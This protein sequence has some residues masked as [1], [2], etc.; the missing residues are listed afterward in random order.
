MSRA[1]RFLQ[2]HPSA[3]IFGLLVGVWLAFSWPAIEEESL[4]LF[5][6]LYPPAE[7]SAYDAIH[8]GETIQ[9]SMQVK[10]LRADCEY[11]GRAAYGRI[12][13]RGL[14]A[15]VPLAR[16]DAMES[17]AQRPVGVLT[18]AGRWSAK[19]AAGHT[20]IEVWTLYMCD[21]R[22]VQVKLVNLPIK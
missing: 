22:Q 13:A 19:P 20:H 18:D 5:D 10:R 16:L 21:G 6:R 3:P 17:R 14:L 4:Q 12:G 1:S 11:V 2:L 9:W 7:G 8:D 15:Q